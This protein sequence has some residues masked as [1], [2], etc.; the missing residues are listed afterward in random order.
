MDK[1]SY[2]GWKNHATWC[3]NLW[4][5]NEEGTNNECLDIVR[6]A[7][8]DY[9][10]A[11]GIKAF[12][13]EL[14]DVELKDGAGFTRDLVGSALSDVDWHEVVEGFKEQTEGEEDAPEEVEVAD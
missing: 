14:V 4:L 12:V 1:E 5:T 8:S 7:R 13:D 10:A 9:D 3:V 2:N 11:Q 6:H